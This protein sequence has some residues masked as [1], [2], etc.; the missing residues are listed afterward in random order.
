MTIKNNTA[1]NSGLA[2]FSIEGLPKTRRNERLVTDFLTKLFDTE[3]F[4]S[5]TLNNW[6]GDTLE[7]RYARNLEESMIVLEARKT[8]MSL[9]KNHD[10]RSLLY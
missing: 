9:Q 6:K 5:E 3:M 8:D 4:S 2:F 7:I 10:Q 1:G